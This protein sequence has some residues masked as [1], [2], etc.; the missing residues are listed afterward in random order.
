MKELREQTSERKDKKLK[1]NLKKE[2]V[3]LSI[4]I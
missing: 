2:G 4:V 3:A 1:K